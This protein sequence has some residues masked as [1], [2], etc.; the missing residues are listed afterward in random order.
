MENYWWFFMYEK[1][2][3]IHWGITYGW[4]MFQYTYQVW[5]SIMSSNYDW[6]FYDEDTPEEEV[7]Q[8]YLEA[9]WIGINEGLE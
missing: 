7:L 2:Y 1:L 9:F 8:D 3:D 6:D 5:A 4:D